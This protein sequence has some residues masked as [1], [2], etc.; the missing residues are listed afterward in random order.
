MTFHDWPTTPLAK[1]VS[2]IAAWITAGWVAGTLLGQWL[3]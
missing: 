2:W 3:L 1:K